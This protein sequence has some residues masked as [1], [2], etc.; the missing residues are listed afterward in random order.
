MNPRQLLLILRARYKAVIG[1]LVFAVAAALLVG[2]FTPR[3]YTAETSIMVD[4]RAPDPIAS[5]LLP[6]A[7]NAGSVGTQIDII[8]SDRVAKKVIRMLRLAEGASVKEAW[9]AATEGKGKIE[10]WMAA[11]LQKGLIITPSRDSNL[12]AI[13]FRGTDPDFVAAIANAFAQ[14]YIEA[15]VELRVEPA[16]QYAEWFAGQSKVL[17]EGVEKAQARVSE[18]QQKHGI[19]VTDEN[20][21]VELVKLNEL[22]ARL[23]AAQS[24]ARDAQI[25]QRPGSGASD[26]LPEV[27]QNA[28]VAGLRMGVNQLEVRLKEAESNFGVNHPQYRRMQ[29]ELAELRV[30]LEA[31]VRHVASSYTATSGA[32]GKAREADLR[33]MIEAQKK[34][35]LDKRSKRDEIVVLMRDVDTA[36]RAYEAV[37]SRYH[38]TTLE[39]QANRTNV[40]VLTPAVAPVQPTFPKPLDQMLIL[41][42]A[43]GL[44]LGCAAAYG[45]EMLDRRIRCADDLA[46]MLQLPVL[47][48][49]ESARRSPRIGLGNRRLALTA[50]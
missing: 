4:I 5:L 20:L 10:D 16:R 18:F 33:T 38:Q 3:R 42:I 30:R 25:K 45:L 35:L 43:A 37:T 31:E 41:A 47:G 39:S 9:T 44:V 21:D 46:E 15:S 14:A 32:I 1:V 24:D 11:W 13:S 48:V 40:S 28:V 19:V 36:K 17:R 49:I 27:M 2:E 8:R 7:M 6:S 23:T 26:T 50:R 22:S 12:I 29:S 34:A